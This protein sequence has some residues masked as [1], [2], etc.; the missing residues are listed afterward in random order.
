MSFPWLSDPWELCCPSTCCPTNLPPLL[1]L[2]HAT[3]LCLPLLL[4]QPGSE[5]G[6]E[7]TLTLE[8]GP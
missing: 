8:A 1:L 2:P 7:A 6:L 4:L 3:S 5:A